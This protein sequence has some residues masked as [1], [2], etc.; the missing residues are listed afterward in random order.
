MTISSSFRHVIIT[1]FNVRS[2]GREVKIRSQ[3]EWLA[4]RFVLF[5]KYCLPSVAAQSNQDFIWL[6]YF[7]SQTPQVY[8]D[9]IERHARS[10]ANLRVKYC[11]S[12]EVDLMQRD[13][14]S[15]I[16]DPPQ[17]L[18]TTRMDNDDGLHRDFVGTLQSHLRFEER[19]ALNFPVG[20]ILA[21]SK[22]YLH[23]DE[24]NPFFSLCERYADF[25]TV[26][27]AQHTDVARVFSTRQLPPAPM[28]LQVVHGGNVSNKVRGNRISRQV[29]LT[30]FEAISFDSGTEITDRAF[31]ITL[32][33]V[34]AGLVR[35]ARDVAIAV[36]KPLVRQI[37]P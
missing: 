19:E 30:G 34:T 17:W 18:L 21:G 5:E 15:E 10:Y 25:S 35:R 12:F 3:P 13:I 27:S 32:E 9:R 31:A 4:S 24:S 37:R 29:A 20:I 14:R 22:T 1:R 28:W 16:V 2:G 11:D 23:R 33:N 26:W 8:R 36:V 7:D 6:T